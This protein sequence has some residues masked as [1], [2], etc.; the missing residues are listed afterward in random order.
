MGFLVGLE[1]EA[2]LQL[3]VGFRSVNLVV[4]AFVAEVAV[5]GLPQPQDN[6]ESLLALL[7][8]LVHGV[9]LDAVEVQVGGEGPDTDAPIEPPPGH[10][11]QHG[12][13]MGGIDRVVQG[14]HGD[15]GGQDDVFGEGQRLGD[16]QFRHRGVFPDLGDMLPDPCL[17]VA[18]LVGQDQQLYVA[19]IGVGVG[20][21][22]GM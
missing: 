13:A 14:K 12:Y 7:P 15:A 21:S 18:Q 3:R 22:R 10:V 2:A 8:H 1:I 5:L 17:V 19:V 11:V 4:L 16:E 6:V 9:V 20:P